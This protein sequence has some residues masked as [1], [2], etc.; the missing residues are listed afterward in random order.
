MPRIASSTQV[1]RL[2]AVSAACGVLAAFGYAA[3]DATKVVADQ[4]PMVGWEEAAA[5]IKV[6]E[7]VAARQPAPPPAP[8]NQLLFLFQAGNDIYLKLSDDEPA[9]G[10]RRLLEDGVT[11]VADVAVAKLP[12]KFRS[13][14]TKTFTVDGGCPATIK[15]FAVVTRMEGS[16]GYAGLDDETWTVATAAKAGT[17]QLAARLDVAME[18]AKGLYARD[19]SLAPLNELFD[20]LESPELVDTARAALLATEASADAQI[21]WAEHGEGSWIDHM[22]LTSFVRRNEVTGELFIGLHANVEEMGCGGPDINLWALFRVRRDNTLETVVVKKLDSLY[23]I[24]R[25]IDVDNDGTL[26]LVGRD[27]LG[28]S[29]VLTRADGEEISKLAMPFHG[30]PC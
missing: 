11:T 1:P 6:S 14:T 4:P 28:T 16:P 29:T 9:H 21:A 27:W 30:C 25:I 17:S 18:C 5:P 19:A 20:K 22:R 2:I 23:T 15:D 3:H 26:E 24:E 8:T 7:L 10:K 13:W 12:A